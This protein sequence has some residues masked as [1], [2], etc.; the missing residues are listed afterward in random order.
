M[1]TDEE[2][3]AAKAEFIGI[4]LETSD[5]FNI[6]FFIRHRKKYVKKNGG[7]R[8][9]NPGLSRPKLEIIPLDQIPTHTIIRRKSN[10][11]LVHF[12]RKTL[13]II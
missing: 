10:Q 3:E 13:Q 6:V 5:A 7:S 8:E 11:I 9:S 12:L 1:D 4:D 2:A